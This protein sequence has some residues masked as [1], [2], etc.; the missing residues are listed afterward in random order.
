VKGR[1]EPVVEV[2]KEEVPNV[3]FA[4]E[5]EVEKL[6]ASGVAKLVLE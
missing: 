3:G 4:K 6:G 2:A 5:E 1:V